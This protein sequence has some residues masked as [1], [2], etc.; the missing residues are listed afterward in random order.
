MFEFQYERKYEYYRYRDRYRDRERCL[1]STR[2]RLDREK[3][4]DT[5]RGVKG[6]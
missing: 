5:E 4:R 1:V 3:E 6:H 2:E